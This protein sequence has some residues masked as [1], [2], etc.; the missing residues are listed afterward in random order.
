RKDRVVHSGRRLYRAIHGRP[1]PRGRISPTK[2]IP[3]TPCMLA[4]AHGARRRT[5]ARAG[6]RCYVGL[7]LP[8]EPAVAHAAMP[9][10]GRGPVARLGPRARRA[11][12]LMA[13]TTSPVTGW[14]FFL[15]LCLA[16]AACRSRRSPPRRAWTL[17]DGVCRRRRARL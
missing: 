11:P 4:V 17:R 16:R 15:S 3:R 12:G 6:R 1:N 13:C 14:D 10:D 5:I 8:V 2:A 7:A 9:V